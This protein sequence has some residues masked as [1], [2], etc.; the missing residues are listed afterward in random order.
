MDPSSHQVYGAGMIEARLSRDA[1]H[2]IEDMARRYLWWKAVAAD[3]HSSERMIAQ[4]MRFGTY[5]DIRKMEL[6]VTP[7]VLAEAMRTSAPGW[8]DDRS[9]GFW[10]GRLSLAGETDIPEQRP[11]RT[12]AHA[13]ML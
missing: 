4:I 6:I 9:W 13:N 12:F 2:A 3:G 8:F 1:I 10:R 11:Q 5:D 7:D